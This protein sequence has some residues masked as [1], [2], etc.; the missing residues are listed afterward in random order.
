MPTK[1]PLIRTPTTFSL[2]THTEITLQNGMTLIAVEDTSQPLL[3]MSIVSQSGAAED[4]IAG[5]TNF[6]ATLM[7]KGTA[8]PKRTL[9]AQ[10]LAEEIDFTGGSLSVSC[11]FDSLSAHLSILSDFTA[12]GLDLLTDVVQHPSFPPE[13]I[14]RVRQ[15]T[16]VEIEQ[17]NSDAAYLSSIAFTQG[18]FRGEK[19][20]HPVVGTLETVANFQQADCQRA[21]LRSL[22]PDNLFIAAAGNFRAHDL[23]EQ[24]QER[25]GK[26]QSSNGKKTQAPSRQVDKPQA[27]NVVLIE[28]PDA[29][30]T[31]LRM[32]FRTVNRAEEDFIPMQFLNTIFGGS[33]ISRLNHN[34]REEKGYTYGVHSSIDAR[35]HASVLTVS[36]HVGS[37]VVES[38]VSEVLREIERLRTEPVTDDELETTRKYMIGSFALRTETPTQVV[39]LLSTLELYGLPKDYHSRYL[40]ELAAMTKDRLF[41]VQQRRFSTESVVIAA[42]GNVE[43]LRQKLR[44]FGAVSVVDVNGVTV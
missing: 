13:E 11:V 42:S 14:D 19:Y 23:A 22:Q 35:K 39:S 1:P 30:Q 21:Y 18:M 4:N 32:G 8:S 43:H 10:A 36:S 9:D 38:A 25:I 33:F 3:T 27:T 16:L 24:I 2:P 5:E 26:H 41:E 12:T 29:A 15:Q 34:L 44:N 6:M 28:K 7:N 31:S 37:D 20:G 40:A 17:A